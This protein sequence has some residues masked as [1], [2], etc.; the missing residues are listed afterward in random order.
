VPPRDVDV[1]VDRLEYLRANPEIRKQMGRNA[2]E[3]ASRFTWNVYSTRAVGELANLL[4][5]G[6]LAQSSLA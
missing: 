2:R 4:E 5:V 3:Q 6:G 1:I